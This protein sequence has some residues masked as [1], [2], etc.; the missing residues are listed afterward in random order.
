MKVTL[1][2]V[3][4]KLNQ[5]ES[6]ALAQKLRE[7][8]F[9]VVGSI[10]KADVVVINT[11]TVTN[12]ADSKS[13]QHM[14]Q[15]KREGKKVVVT[16]CYA[17]TDGE[18]ILNRGLADIILPND[19]KFTLPSLLL[20][21]PE[22]KQEDF[23][24]VVEYERTRA[25][26]KIQ[27]GCNRFCSY[28]KIPYARGRSRSLPL[29]EVVRRFRE[30]ISG[31]YKEIILTG[32]NISDYQDKEAT[33]FTL[34][35]RLLEEKGDFR[36][37]LSSL[38]P[39]QFE[40]AFLTLLHH[41]KLTP[42]FHLSLQSGSSEVLQRM[43]RHYTAEF[44]L[45][46][47]E[48]IRLARKD[49]ALTTDIIVGFPKETE[50]EFQKTVEL[51]Q[52]VRFSRVHLFSYSPRAGTWAASQAQL[53]EEL[54]KRRLHELEQKAIASA[55]SWVKETLLGKPSTVLVEEST[56]EYSYGYTEHYLYARVK[57][58]F[59]QNSFIQCMPTD[60]WIHQGAVSI[61]GESPSA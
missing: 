5:F 9:E 56:D 49:T 40:E 8:G 43:R 1:V 20:E 59:P 4:C 24:L 53:P 47:C 33:L 11:C 44:F 13:R 16:G 18:E 39:D 32:V 34:V 17:T 54:K 26:L 6:D 58:N 46:L 45:T 3:G 50:E 51:V 7:S 60:T 41:P 52:K 61:K 30:L 14:K 10:D 22:E 12:S 28:C 36:I 55:E 37:R 31:G 27:D 48:K 38:Q 29:P 2:T 15:A 23:P 35:S 25:Y 42:H 57:G 19:K 21:S